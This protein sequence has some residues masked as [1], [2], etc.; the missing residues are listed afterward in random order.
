MIL[1]EE[2]YPV[3]IRWSDDCEN[4][5]LALKRRNDC[6]FMILKRRIS[7]EK[8]LYEIMYI[9]MAYYQT[10]GERLK[11]DNLKLWEI[12]QDYFNKS[13]YKGDIVVRFGEVIIPYGKRISDVLVRDVIIIVITFNVYPIKYMV[14][15]IQIW[16]HIILWIEQ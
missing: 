7:G 1:L 11:N 10:C 13:S 3:K 4:P 5:Y 12:L 2:I 9:G 16:E 14:P 6:V 8:N 15:T